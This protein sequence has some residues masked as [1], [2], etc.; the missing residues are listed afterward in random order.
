MIPWPLKKRNT[1]RKISYFGFFC[2]IKCQILLYFSVCVCP[3]KPM[4][5]FV[6]NG[7]C[8]RLHQRLSFLKQTFSYQISETLD[9]CK[10]RSCVCEFF[11]LKRNLLSSI[12]PDE[13]LSIFLQ[14]SSK[15]ES[16]TYLMIQK[17]SSFPPGNRFP[18][19]V[20]S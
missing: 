14:K 15:R 11:G 16:V 4:E 2:S 10:T 12:S 3:L 13:K 18:L 5:K 7:L 8:R 9:F 19:S 20:F 1:F 6:S 17:A